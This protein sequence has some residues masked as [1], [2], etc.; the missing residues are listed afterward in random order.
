[1]PGAMP[2]TH[3][4]I[5]N[6]LFT[7]LVRLW[8][9]APIH[10]VYCGLRGFTK[11]LYER[12]DQRCTGM[13]FATEM[14]IKASRN[15]EN[16]AEVPVTLHPDGRKAHAPHLKTVRDG[17][18]TLRFFL[19]CSPRW[20]FLIPGFLLILCGVLGY[21]LAWPGVT[22]GSVQFGPH[23]M[24]CASV[25][26]LCGYQSILFAVFT[27]TLGMVEGILPRDPRLYRLFELVPLEKGLIGAMAGLIAGVGLI[28]YAMLTW[29]RRDFGPLDY[30][31]TMRQVIPGSLLVA[32]SIQTMFSSFFVSILGMGRR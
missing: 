24:L 10:D 26:I 32:L 1:M 28:G 7:F 4:V 6:P 31:V 16:I 30:E 8:F 5:G 29:S 11:A 18:R 9:K 15:R 2:V 12:L 23:T 20:L 25:A 14:V 17:W 22:L 27:M 21:V 3:R 19:M 13:E